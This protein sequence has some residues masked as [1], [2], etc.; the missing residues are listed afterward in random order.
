MLSS[1]RWYN[2]AYLESS[3]AMKYNTDKNNTDDELSG[4]I[5]S[6]N[7]LFS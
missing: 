2:P 4:K 7:Q 1:R 5:T 6:F 3:V